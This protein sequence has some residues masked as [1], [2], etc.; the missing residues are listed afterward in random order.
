MA[1]R[2]LKLERLERRE[3]LAGDLRIVELNYH[4]HDAMPEFG[5]RDSD[6]DKFEFIEFQNVGDASMSLAG[7][8]LDEGVAFQFDGQVLGPG[9]R[10]VATNNVP[11][12]QSR[13]GNSVRIAAGDDG[14]GGDG[15]EFGGSL[16]NSGELVVLRNPTGQIV[17]RFEFFD[18]GEWPTRADGRGSSLELIDPLS[19][20]NDPKS[21]RASGEYGGSPGTAGVGMLQDVI[22]NELLTHTDLPE[23]DTVELYNRTDEQRD[24]TGWYLTDESETLSRFQFSANQGLIHSNDYLVLDENDLGY[25]LRGQEADDLYLIEADAIGRPIRFVDAVE[26]AAT[27]N[28]VS[29]GRWNN[30]DGELFPMFEQTFEDTN[31]GP[32]IGPVVISEIQYHPQVPSAGPLLQN[33]LE[34]IEITNRS[35]VPLGIGQ[36]RLHSAVEFVF[37]DATVISAGATQ[38]I[39]GFD[40]NNNVKRNA[41]LAAYQLPNETRLLGPYSDA[42][43]PNPDQLDDAGET[44][45][46]DRPEDPLQLGLGY[47]LIDRVSYRSEG[48]GWPVDASGSGKSITRVDLEAY[49]D[50]G[51]SWRAGAPTPD[52]I[53]L[54][55]D[56]NSDGEVDDHDIDLLCTAANLGGRNP[57]FDLNGDDLVSHADVLYLVEEILGTSVGDANLDGVFDS[58]D[59]VQVFTLGQYEDGSVGNSRWASGDWNCDQEFSTSDLVTA[60]QA[61]GYV[62]GASSAPDRGETNRA[63]DGPL[64]SN[65]AA[66]ASI[67]LSDFAAAIDAVF[68]DRQRRSS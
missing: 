58:G 1:S 10:I 62:S 45:I 18:R 24:M 39:V 12:F 14:E 63:A 36:W 20:A 28:G 52:R 8:Y 3:M 54:A 23:I 46:L 4:P 17:Q 51:S 66:Q 56:L 27:Q 55:G 65:V 40:P 34:F 64:N 57:R 43:D 53:G 49:G 38:L 44:L 59:L 41:F 37:P 13:Y 25:A 6:A 31:T 67:S 5:E 50:F 21:W 42:E 16:N 22:I 47:V 19:D 2:G 11:D 48:E 7:F 15:G 33:D 30:A 9:E 35:G 26:F 61:G 32:L 68:N 60:F 29:L